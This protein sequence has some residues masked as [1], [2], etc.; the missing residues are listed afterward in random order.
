MNIINPSIKLKSIIDR[1]DYEKIKYLENICHEHDKTSLKLELDYKLSNSKSS[2][3]NLANINEFMYF[4]ND[5]LIGYLGICDFGGD[6]I[7]VNGMVHPQYRRMGVFK[8][9]FSLVRDEWQKRKSVSM[10]L[11]SDHQSTSGI[12]FIKSVC[13]GYA[14]SEYDMILNIESFQKL[15]SKTLK[16]RKITKDDASEIARQNSMYFNMEFSEEDNIET[17]GGSYNNITYMAEKEHEAIGKVRIE[18]NNK[19]GGIYG[20]GVLPEY[21]GLGYGRQILSMAIEELLNKNVES[22]FLQVLTNNKNA[23]NLYKSCG[24]SERYTMDYYIIRND[25]GENNG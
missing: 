13:D 16:L 5:E 10:L 1:N 22:I 19:Q 2:E 14:H 24:F 9:L 17:E 23:L 20:L 7:E 25:N 4:N 6:E 18:I 8:R 3:T 15:Q 12:E 11:L 21:R